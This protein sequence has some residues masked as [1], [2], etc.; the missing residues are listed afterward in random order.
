MINIVQYLKQE[1]SVDHGFKNPETNI[2]QS[3]IE[4]NQF[5]II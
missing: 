2:F 4:I 5:S 1:K 3:T